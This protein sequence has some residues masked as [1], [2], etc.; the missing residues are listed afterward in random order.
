MRRSAK[1]AILPVVGLFLLAVKLCNPAG[2][3]PKLDVVTVDHSLGAFLRSVV[4]SAVEINGLNEI[5][6]SAN[7][8][9]S[10]VRHSR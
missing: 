5:A 10:I 6:I 8:V 9:R 1:T 7:Q 3:L 4:V 2:V